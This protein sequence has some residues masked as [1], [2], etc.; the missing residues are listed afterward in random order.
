M[1]VRTNYSWWDDRLKQEAPI[2]RDEEKEREKAHI[3]DTPK[4]IYNY[5]DSEVYGC[6]EYKKALATAVW[7]S[8]R[9]HTKTNFLVIGPS[10]C[11]K[12]ELAR[13]LKK[14]YY[15]TVIFDAT[16]VSPVTYKGTATISQCLLEVDTEDYS[17]PPWIFIDE[18]DKA[19]IG[20]RELGPMVMNELLKMMEGCELYA[21][22]DERHRVRVDSR[23][24][25]FVLLGTFNGIKKEH[26]NPIGFCAGD[27]AETAVT[28]VT[29]DM[30]CKSNILSNEL[31]GRINGGILEVEPMD[32]KKAEAILSDKRYSPITR[33][34]QK[35]RIHID[36]TEEKWK[37]LIGM[38]SKYGVRGIYS[39]IQSRINDALFEDCNAN[40]ILI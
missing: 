11:G 34:E 25:N 29:R 1:P 10:G 24:A 33:L 7:S 16:S 28:H 19:L 18:V 31:L 20:R 6:H 35:Y 32:E 23:R 36:V 27:D 15:N 2:R 37:E 39:E 9:L 30:L 21:G 5:F 8:L 22:A 4:N 12:S 3:F 17:V 26:K 13:V 38:T 14:I 40:S